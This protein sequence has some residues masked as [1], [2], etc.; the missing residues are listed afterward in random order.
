MELIVKYE[1][2]IVKTCFKKKDKLLKKTKS[3]GDI[4]EVVRDQI[5][6]YHKKFDK[7][8]SVI[9]MSMSTFVAMINETTVITSLNMHNDGRMFL[10]G[11]RLHVV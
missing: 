1:N 9:K 8:P 2:E 7:Y 3:K 5:Y 10:H 4:N 6:E 11:V